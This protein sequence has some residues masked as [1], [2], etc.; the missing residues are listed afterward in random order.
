MNW[1]AETGPPAVPAAPLAQATPSRARSVSQPGRN[2]GPFGRRILMGLR[3]PA[4]KMAVP[5]ERTQKVA[6]ITALWAVGPSDPGWCC[7]PR[8]FSARLRPGPPEVKCFLG[9][10]ATR[11]PPSDGFPWSDCDPHP[12]KGRAFSARLQPGPL[13]V[14]CFFGSNPTRAPRRDVFYRSDGDPVPSK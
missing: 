6:R 8:A 2:V 7:D 13:E 10:I 3:F 9:P 12:S 11:A 1:L 4:D 5:R 14:T